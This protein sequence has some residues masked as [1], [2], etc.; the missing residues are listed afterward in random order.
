MKEQRED[1]F[2]QVVVL[3]TAVFAAIQEY[4]VFPGMRVEVAVHDDSVF[5]H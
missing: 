5:V 3:I 4:V 1:L 2:P